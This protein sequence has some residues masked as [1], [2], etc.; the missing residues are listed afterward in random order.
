[1]TPAAGPA[2]PRAIGRSDLISGAVGFGT[3]AIGGPHWRN[4][5]PIG[6][7]EV[8]DDESL[9]AIGAALDRGV[10][11]FDT[12]DVYGTGHSERLLGRALRGRD[13]VVVATKFGYTYDEETRE[14]PGTDARPEYIRQACERSLARLGRETVDLY[15]FHLADHPLERADEVLAT[16]EDLVAEGKV[17]WF[18]WSTDDPARAAFFGASP[19]CVAVE[20]RMNLVERNDAMLAVCDELDL[21]AVVRSPLGMGLLSG[22]LTADTRFRAD[23]LRSGW[24]MAGEVG[25]RL[26]R[27]ERVRAL[28]TADGATPAQGALRWLLGVSAHT[29]PVPGIR[30]VAQAEEN[31]GAMALGPFSAAQLAAIDEALGA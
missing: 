5:A 15:L 8:D 10:T 2:T 20:C 4:G 3:W 28:L 9:A 31:A 17:R 29:L 23:D 6:W 14:S 19:H 7:G 21:A 22:R 18:G 24:D 27:L 30:T 12:A 1:M 25:D 26:A 11:F 13:D 16:L